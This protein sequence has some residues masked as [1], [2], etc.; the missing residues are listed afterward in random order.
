M[1]NKLSRFVGGIN[2]TESET[3]NFDVCDLFENLLQKMLLF[4]MES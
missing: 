3:R 1:E 2:S 4:S